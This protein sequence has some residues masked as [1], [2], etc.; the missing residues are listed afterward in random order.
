MWHQRECGIGERF[1]WRIQ[2]G[3]KDCDPLANPMAGRSFDPLDTVSEVLPGRYL[4][5][6]EKGSRGRTQRIGDQAD[7]TTGQRRP[8]GGI[9]VAVLLERVVPITGLL[10]GT[11]KDVDYTTNNENSCGETAFK[12]CCL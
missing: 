2:L 8:S 4:E 5:A 1:Q 7:R 9:Q 6:G 12:D 10:M 3:S 11:S